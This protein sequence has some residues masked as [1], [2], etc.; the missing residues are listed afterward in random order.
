MAGVG[1]GGEGRGGR[2]WCRVGWAYWVN[3]HVGWFASVSTIL[4]IESRL[5]KQ[6]LLRDGA[7]SSDVVKSKRS[8]A[9]KDPRDSVRGQ[10]WTEEGGVRR[11]PLGS[12][13]LREACTMQGM[14]WDAGVGEPGLQM[15][16]LELAEDVGGGGGLRKR[17]CH[18]D[19]R[20]QDVGAA[21]GKEGKKRRGWLALAARVVSV[22]GKC[23]A[24][25]RSAK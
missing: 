18:L 23:G 4:T 8:G 9:K 3:F 6:L 5:C 2:E 24:Q 13:Q 1:R 20:L 22:Q 7:C 19:G 16:G 14:G 15:D 25:R 21:I 11:L 17:L 12:G 10:G